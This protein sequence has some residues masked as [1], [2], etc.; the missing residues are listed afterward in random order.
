MQEVLIKTFKKSDY[1][2]A[3]ALLNNG[4]LFFQ[5]VDAYRNMEG[6]CQ[7]NDFEEGGVVE[8]ISAYIDPNVNSFYIGQP[9]GK[10]FF[11]DWAAVRKN[12]PQL[13]NTSNSEP[14]RFRISYVVDWLIY[15]MTYISLSTLNRSEVYETIANLEQKPYCVLIDEAQ[16]LT[17]NQVLELVIITKEWNIPVICYGLKVDFQGNLFEGSKAL[18]SYADALQELV[19]IC[20]CG[21]KARFNARKING[22]YLFDGEQILI[23]EDE[24]YEPLCESCFMKKVLLPYSKQFQEIYKKSENIYNSI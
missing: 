19:A 9:N 18:L 4:E 12:Y 15:C 21:K 3:Q 1:Q 11:V 5:H 20:N 16:F 2:Y 24:S 7:R 6:D 13:Q 10:Q 14:L 22:K 8:N 17:L 23:G